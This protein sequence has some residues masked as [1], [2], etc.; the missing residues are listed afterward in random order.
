MTAILDRV[1][2]SLITNRSGGTVGKVLSSFA[3]SHD[4]GPGLLPVSVD[5]EGLSVVRFDG[6][7]LV[8]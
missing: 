1:S 4:T 3:R 2:G 8:P 5:A 7:N 6:T